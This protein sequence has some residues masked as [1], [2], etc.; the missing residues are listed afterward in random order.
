[1][2]NAK[3]DE[4]GRVQLSEELLAALGWEKGQELLIRTDDDLLLLQPATPTAALRE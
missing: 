3:L 1:M 4:Q 2:A